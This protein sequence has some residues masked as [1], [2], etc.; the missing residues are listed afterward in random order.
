MEDAYIQSL[1]P[2]ELIAHDIAKSHLGMSFCLV[3]SNGY[4]AWRK[5]ED[6]TLKRKYVDDTQPNSSQK[7]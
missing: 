6:E 7:K 1:T 2:K 3:K 5:K 4:L